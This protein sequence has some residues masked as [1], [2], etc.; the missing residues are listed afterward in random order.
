MRVLVPPRDEVVARVGIGRRRVCGATHR[1][2]LPTKSVPKRSIAGPDRMGEV[3]SSK[4]DRCC[5]GWAALPVPVFMDLVISV[6]CASPDLRADFVE[7][8]GVGGVRRFLVIKKGVA[9]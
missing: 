1:P 6:G 4:L 8:E 7:G 3:G 2:G 9:T 5:C